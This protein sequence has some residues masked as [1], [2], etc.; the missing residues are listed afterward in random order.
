RRAWGPRGSVP[1]ADVVS[2]PDLPGTRGGDL[3]APSGAPRVGTSAHRARAGSG[4]GRPGPVQVQ[5]LPVLASPRPRGAPPATQASGR[6]SPVGA[7][8]AHAAVAD[9]REG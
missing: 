9:G 3:R 2:P 8:P 1:S 6:L 5:H 4:R 7:G